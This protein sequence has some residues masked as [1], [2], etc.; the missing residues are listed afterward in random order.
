MTYTFGS[1]TF[2]SAQ[3]GNPMSSLIE[4]AD[5]EDI[6]LA[7]AK[8]IM[9]SVKCF[10]QAEGNP[11]PRI[12]LSRVGGAPNDVADLARISFLVLAA[13]RPQA[14]EHAK[15]LLG[16]LLSLAYTGP[17]STPKGVLEAAEVVSWIWFPD[18]VSQLPRYIIDARV[19]TRAS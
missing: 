18:P 11:L 12:Q 1:G 13:T 6:A 9:G 10:L 16:E 19:V 14:K 4:V 7:W 3:M 17:V 2:G 5:A 8:T 15:T